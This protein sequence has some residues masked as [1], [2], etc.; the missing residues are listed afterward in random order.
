MIYGRLIIII[1]FCYY[2]CYD[3]CCSGYNYNYTD[4]IMPC[5]LASSN[6]ARA[7]R[8]RRACV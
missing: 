2:Y 8:A 3:C 6:A 4:I 1:C 7:L 5:C